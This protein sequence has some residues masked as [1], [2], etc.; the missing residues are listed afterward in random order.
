MELI[1]R[2]RDS[3]EHGVLVRSAYVVISIR[4]P[5]RRKARIPEQPGQRDVLYLAFD[6][7]EPVEG[8][9]PPGGVVL[10]TDEQARQVWAF[11]RRWE[12][13]VGAVVVHCEQGVSRSPAVAAAL[14]RAYGGDE[15]CFFR[16]Y[17]PNRHVYRVMV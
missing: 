13:Q 8:L 6:D 11:V 15:N 5:V 4:D 9:R 3:V 16:E 2:D 1:V 12:G 17:Q 14:C 7:A 10:M